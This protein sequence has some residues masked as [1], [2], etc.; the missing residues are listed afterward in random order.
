MLRPG[1]IVV[2]NFAGG[3]G[4]SH[5]IEDGL[6]IHVDIGI[7]HDPDAIDMYKLNH[8]ETKTYC[9]SVWDVDPVEACAGRPVGLAW[10][11]PDCKHYSIARGGKPVDRNIRGLAW[12]AVRW[13][14]KTDMRIFMLENVKEFKTWGPLIENDKGKLFP[15]PE[16]KGQTFEAFIKVLTTGITPKNPEWKEIIHTLD[17]D[18]YDIHTKLR[19]FKG[20]GYKIEHRELVASDYGA[21]T[22]RKRFFMVARKDEQPIAWPNRTHADP[23]LDIVKQGLVKPWKT[24]ADIIDWSIPCKS[25]FDRPK[26]LAEKSLERIFKGVIKEVIDNPEPYIAPTTATIT[27]FITEYANASSQRNMSVNEPLKTICAQV[28]GG[29]FALV[30]P[31]LE[32]LCES[33]QEIITSHLTKFRGTNLGTKASEPIPTISAGGNHIGEVR[34]FLVKYYGQGV[35]KT[36]NEPLDTITTKDR[37]GLVIVSIKGVPYQIVD[38]GLRM[39]EPYELFAAHGF[40]PSFKISHDSRG[41]KLSKAK[42]VARVGNSVPPPFSSALVRSNFKNDNQDLI[43]A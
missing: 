17:L 16:R 31:K 9:E 24:A 21:A 20:L 32:P 25:I 19:M 6:D 43:A 8:P 30:E 38:I 1:E 39:F 3:G 36:I 29:H 5:G 34:V 15:C 4:A 42:Q 2:D 40:S 28:K 18:Q 7:N 22:S 12:V 37:F 33:Y 11:S 13:A 35:C 10:F 26:P 27:P 14:L 41:K 23:R